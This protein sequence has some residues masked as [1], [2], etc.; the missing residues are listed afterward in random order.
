M[1][2]ESYYLQDF[3]ERMMQM[4]R[5]RAFF[6]DA[7]HPRR[8]RARR[9]PRAPPGPPPRQLA[10]PVPPPP[11]AGLDA[12]N[13]IVPPQVGA[14]DEG[15]AP[16]ARSVGDVPVRRR[17]RPRAPRGHRG[18]GAPH[19]RGDARPSQQGLH[20]RRREPP[21]GQHLRLGVGGPGVRVL[22]RAS[23][24]TRS[25]ASTASTPT[26]DFVEIVEFV[27]NPALDG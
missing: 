6:T 1:L 8:L 14:P 22:Q 16:D 11:P 7:R 3:V 18:G 23:S 19:V 12:A 20:G 10:H 4:N 13:G 26:I 27:D 5:G 15:G 21:G 24:A 25:R 17:L 9:L 2:D